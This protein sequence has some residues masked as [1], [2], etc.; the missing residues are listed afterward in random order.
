MKIYTNSRHPVCGF[1]VSRIVAACLASIL[2]CA[3]VEKGAMVGNKPA[4][5]IFRTHINMIIGGHL[6]RF[7]LMKWRKV[8]LRVQYI[9]RKGAANWL[10]ISPH[11][12]RELKIYPC[13][14]PWIFTTYVSWWIL[15][16]LLDCF[17]DQ[18]Y[19]RPEHMNVTLKPCAT[20]HSGILSQAESYIKAEPSEQ[21]RHY[22]MRN[23][24]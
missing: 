22:M 17:Y 3:I 21:T 13:N 20:K 7:L 2:I 24:Q 5:L 12:Y 4:M 18:E 1:W 8:A 16:Y 19:N 9:S 15:L 6:P 11:G 14:N 10:C 23:L